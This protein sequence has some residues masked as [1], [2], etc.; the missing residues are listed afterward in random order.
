MTTPSLLDAAGRRT[1]A[2]DDV[3]ERRAATLSDRITSGSAL[4]LPL[5]PGASRP[6]IPCC[7]RSS[8]SSAAG[9]TLATARRSHCAGKQKR[10]RRIGA[11]ARCVAVPGARWVVGVVRLR[12]A[13]VAE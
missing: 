7:A 11:L 5:S 12:A 3:R 4:A 6:V 2:A 8:G 9:V 1:Q 10:S 13:V